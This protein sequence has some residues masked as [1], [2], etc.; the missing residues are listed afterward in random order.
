MVEFQSGHKEELRAI[1]G[2]STKVDWYNK[3]GKP[4]PID[5]S[6]LET[7]ALWELR[8]SIRDFCAH[9]LDVIDQELNNWTSIYC[10]VCGEEDLAY[11]GQ[12]FITWGVRGGYILCPRHT[13]AFDLKGTPEG[14]RLEAEKK[15]IREEQKE[16]AELFG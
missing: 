1:S 13:R 14:E 3:D 15:R 5:I 9:Q 6:Q 8:N 11:R 2:K 7:N 12:P 4:V 16:I 10:S